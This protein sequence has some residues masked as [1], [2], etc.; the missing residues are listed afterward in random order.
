MRKEGWEKMLEADETPQLAAA[1]PAALEVLEAKF[2]ERMGLRRR[3]SHLWGKYYRVNYYDPSAQN[4]IVESHFIKVLE[5][6]I[7]EKN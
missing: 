5:G 3:I 1:P 7:E 6:R 2:P 4:F